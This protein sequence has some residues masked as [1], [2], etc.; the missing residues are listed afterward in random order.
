[1]E[2]K[3]EGPKRLRVYVLS[4]ELWLRIQKW[5]NTTHWKGTPYLSSQIVRAA[6]SI[7]SNIA[8]GCSR[9]SNLDFIRFLRIAKGSATELKHHLKGAESLG[10][11]E[12]QDALFFLDQADAAE[13]MLSKLIKY[14][15]QLEPKKRRAKQS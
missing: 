13:K 12:G 1:M 15:R 10:I 4:N 11:L 2:Q 6:H 3:D 8:E 5:S 9:G 14:R 7:P